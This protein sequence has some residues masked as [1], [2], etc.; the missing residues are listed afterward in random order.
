MNGWG[1]YRTGS[2]ASVTAASVTAASVA[3]TA[4]AATAV[5]S[6]HVIHEAKGRGARRLIWRREP[7][8]WPEESRGTEDDD[9]G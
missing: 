2:A 6:P 8:G 3:A 5:G 4:V 9:G 1:T 7:C